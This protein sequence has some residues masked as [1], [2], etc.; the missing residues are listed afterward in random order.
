MSEYVFV[1]T[2]A[3]L[4]LLV[5]TDTA[6]ARA[7]ESFQRLAAARAPLITSSYVMVETYALLQSRLGLEAVRAFRGEFAPLLDTLW[8]TEETHERALD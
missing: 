8:V 4:A 5:P 2:S 1:D 7:R 3:I 6:H